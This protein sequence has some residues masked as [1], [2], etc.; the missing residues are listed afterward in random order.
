MNHPKVRLG[1][2]ANLFS[3]QMFFENAG[4][5]ELGHTHPFD[6]MTLVAYGAIELEVEGKTKTYAAPTM[7]YIRKDKRHK[8]T[9]IEAGTVAYC[10]H[11]LR[12]G[13]RVEDIIDPDSIPFGVSA[14]EVCCSIVNTETS[15][16]KARE[17]NKNA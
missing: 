1:C 12:D 9:A 13:E 3:R 6:H 11:A 14:S 4:D 17:Q 8:I 5:C 10:I 2:V 15:I 16:R 7:V